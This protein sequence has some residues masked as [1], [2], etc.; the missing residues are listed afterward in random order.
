MF[1]I[2]YYILQEIYIYICYEQKRTGD[3]VMSGKVVDHDYPGSE[4]LSDEELK[5]QVIQQ[6][7]KPIE[8]STKEMKFPTETIDLPSKGLLYPKES[9]LSKGQVEVK[10][11]TAKE[12][13]ILTS[14]NL[15]KNGTVID[16]LLKNL[17]VSPIN[18]DDLLVGD[19]NA[20]MIAA[21]VLAYG[22]DYEVELTSPSSGEKQKETIDLTEFQ[23][24]E[25]DSELFQEGENKFSM[26]LPASKRTIEFKL[27]THGDEKKIQSEIKANK[28]MRR[29][30][31]GVSPELSTR[32]KFMILSVDGELDRTT[33]SK[34]V[35]DEFLSRDSLAFRE[36]MNEISPDIDLTHTYFD[37]NG[38]EHDVQLPMTVQFFWPR[39]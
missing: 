39:A 4:R 24:K 7:A 35:D 15:I 13:D 26:Q 37:E 34:F 12:E 9:P 29:R 23:A 8:K 25:I 6:S 38:D 14:Q 22:K 32:L 27:L 33:I 36:Y 18:Y 28:K 10:Y 20:I 30:I 1:G 21:R 31:N 17:I 11:M 2:F 16:V 19:K 5:N 3:T